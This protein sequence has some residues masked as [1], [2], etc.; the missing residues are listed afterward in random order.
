MRSNIRF[1]ETGFCFVISQT[2]SSAIRVSQA[3]T[4]SLKASLRQQDNA[5]DQ[6]PVSNPSQGP[7]GLVFLSHQNPVLKQQNPKATKGTHDVRDLLHDIHI[8]PLR[9]IRWLTPAPAADS[10]TRSH[11]TFERNHRIAPRYRTSQ[12]PAAGLT[13]AALSRC[14]C[15][16][17]TP[18]RGLHARIS[19]SVVRTPSS[20]LRYSGAGT[21]EPGD[22]FA[23]L[24]MTKCRVL[25]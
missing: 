16:S 8:S 20:V 5:R 22:C 6:E 21:Q 15:H 4:I 1:Q 25:P 19:R 12:F 11:V 13:P 17:T 18:T 23:T 9:I 10:E 3:V 2:S 14:D 7:V 24:A